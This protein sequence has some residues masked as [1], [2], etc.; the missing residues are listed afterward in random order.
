MTTKAKLVS[1]IAAFCL[2]LALLIVGVLAVPTA[3]INMGGQISFEATD[4][5][6]K[7]EIN[8]E[9]TAAHDDTDDKTFKFNADEGAA[10]EAWTGKNWVFDETRTI[11]VTIKVTNLDTVRN[12]NVTF[13]PPTTASNLEVAASSSD[14]QTVSAMKTLTPTSGN[15][16]TYTVIFTPENENLAVNGANWTATLVLANVEADAE[17]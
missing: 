15:V 14:S 5:N 1:T 8:V 10:T 13:T 6:A 2:V 4:V 16:I 3:T 17:G 12:L 11:T 9:G 7:V